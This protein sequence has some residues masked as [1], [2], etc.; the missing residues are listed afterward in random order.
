[1]GRQ[2]LVEWE[3]PHL[4]ADK[5]GGTAG[6]R[7]RLCNTGFQCGE[8][9]PQNLWPYSSV[10]VVVE[11]ETPSLTGDFVGE[12]HRTL[13]YTQTYPPGESAPQE[14]NLLVGSEGSD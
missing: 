7:D 2:Q 1:M 8:I 6:E 4:C 14:A 5:S 10:G 13:E 9:K 12:T 11:G 3:V